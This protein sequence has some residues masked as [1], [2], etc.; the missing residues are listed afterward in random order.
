MRAAKHIWL[1]RIPAAALA[2]AG[3]MTGACVDISERWELD[4][5]R[6]IVVAATDPALA[7]GE[8][9]TLRA[10]TVNSAAAVGEATPG[11]VIVASENPTVM[12]AV[13][14]DLA[15]STITAGSRE[16]LDAARLAL[17][18]LPEEP[19]VI[20]FGARFLIEGKTFDAVKG[21]VFGGEPH[22]NPAAPTILVDDATDKTTVAAG[23]TFDLALQDELP[24][25]PDDFKL[26]W[27]ISAGAMKGSQAVKAKVDLVDVAAG[28]TLQSLVVVRDNKGGAVWA[29][30]TLTVE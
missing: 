29:T 16:A 24:G 11:I 26:S 17:G 5:A 19:L 4:H 20:Q 25:E 12:A 7:P 3:L 23:A 13:S 9:T 14:V 21:I 6:I 30:K 10:L 22:D 15:T 28:A 2:V 18:L 8:S 27:A 1:R